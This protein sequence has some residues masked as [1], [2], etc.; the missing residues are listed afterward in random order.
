MTLKKFIS[1]KF[2]LTKKKERKMLLIAVLFG[3]VLFAEA[4]TPSEQT[5][6][7][8]ILASLNQLASQHTSTSQAQIAMI[9]RSTNYVA[10]CGAFPPPT[11]R[12]FKGRK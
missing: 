2:S 9:L 6:C 4:T 5:I 12:G 7:A 3:L 11:K 8:G 1:T 10:R